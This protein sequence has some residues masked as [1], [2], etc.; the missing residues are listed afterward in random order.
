MSEEANQGTDID[1]GIWNPVEYL[2]VVSD[3][4]EQYSRGFLRCRPEGWFSA[5]AAQWLPLVHSLAIEA[6]FVEIRPMLEHPATTDIGFVASVDDEPLG[7]FCDRDSA[8]IISGAFAPDISDVAGSIVLEYLAR[9]FVTSAGIS[10]SGPN[11]SV[12]RFEPELSAGSIRGTGAIKIT[13]AINGQQAVF[14]IVL[15]KQVVERFDGLWRRQLQSTHQVQESPLSVR[16]ELTHLNI[17][18][19]MLDDYLLQGTIVDLEVPISDAVTLVTD[20]GAWRQG[21]LVQIED[22]FGIES[23]SEGVRRPPLPPETI[24]L[25]IEAGRIELDPATVIE[26]SQP[27]AVLR[28]E[29][30]L[31]DEVNLYA[32]GKQVGKA[33]LKA[34]QGRFAIMVL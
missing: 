4:A 19:D 17:P 25:S 31:S 3:R 32:H 2:K 29:I 27:G 5:F 23:I 34:Y 28:T 6:K 13:A 1:L 24:T 10:W 14:W 21:R 8:S 22:N 9:R 26:M 15:G 7:I 11:T 30:P 16:L 20:D 18:E 33:S 12:T